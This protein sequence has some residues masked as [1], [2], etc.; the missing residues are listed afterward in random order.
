MTAFLWGAVDPLAPF[1][2]VCIGILAVVFGIAAKVSR[3][4]ETRRER[5]RRARRGG[6]VR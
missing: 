5:R 3:W 2:A 6:Y 1:M 4:L